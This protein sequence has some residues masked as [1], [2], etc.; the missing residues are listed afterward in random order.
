MGDLL[1]AAAKHLPIAD[2]LSATIR[3]WGTR[4]GGTD[5]HPEFVQGT[6]LRLILLARQQLK[7]IHPLTERIQ[8]TF[9]H[10]RV[11][12]GLRER[13][14]FR[15]ANTLLMNTPFGRVVG[16]KGCTWSAGRVS[17]AATFTVT[18]L[19]RVRPGTEV[20]AIL[21]EVLRS[22]S[23][24]ERWRERVAELADIHLVEPYGVFDDSAD[25]DVFLLRLVRREPG[26]SKA[27]N[28]WPAWRQHGGS[29][30]GD[31]FDVHVGR[32]VPHRDRK[33]GTEYSYIHPRCV[34]TWSVMREF[35]EKRK[36][37]GPAYQPPFVV[38]RRTSRPGDA[39]RATASVVVGKDL[40]AV[41]NHLIV[42]EPK[43]KTVKVCRALMRHLKSKMVNAFL[44][45]RIR[46]R[47]LTVGAVA[48]IPFDGQ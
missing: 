34:P 29:T 27:A 48:A 1:L 24:S 10:I 46:C 44:D 16:D 36:H 43:D 19:E 32:V 42:C 11:G 33:I 39:Y 2:S 30:I 35:S 40:V 5:L 15:R 18:A 26:R 13:L 21:P 37:R 45:Q 12:D 3:L 47:H 8:D 41:E 31:Y 25:V 9:P 6:K 20:L 7:A 22:G 23:F 4:L 28:K 38:L 17:A 14:L